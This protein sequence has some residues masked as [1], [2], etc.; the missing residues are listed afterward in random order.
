MS[1]EVVDQNHQNILDLIIKVNA[2]VN[3]KVLTYKEAYEVMAS[4]DYETF[5]E[6]SGAHGDLATIEMTLRHVLAQQGMDVGDIL[7]EDR[8]YLARDLQ[9]LILDKETTVVELSQKTGVARATITRILEGATVD[10][11]IYQRL[12][13]GL[14]RKFLFVQVKEFVHRCVNGGNL[15]I[16]EPPNRWEMVVENW[17]WETFRNNVVSSPGWSVE[18]KWK[19]TCEL[20]SVVNTAQDRVSVKGKMVKDV[21][22]PGFY[23][24]LIVKP[25][26][27]QYE[28]I[29]HIGMVHS[30]QE[31]LTVD[32]GSV[33]YKVTAGKLITTTGA[34]LKIPVELDSSGKV[35]PVTLKIDWD[36]E[37]LVPGQVILVDYSDVKLYDTYEEAINDIVDP[38]DE[39][40]KDIKDM[41]LDPPITSEKI[42]EELKQNL[43]EERYE[44]V[45]ELIDLGNG[46]WE[47]VV[48]LDGVTR[49]K[50]IT[51]TETGPTAE[52]QA[53]LLLDGLEAKLKGLD[54][55]IEEPT[56]AAATTAIKAGM[57]ADADKVKTVTKVSDKEY[58]V[59]LAVTVK[60]QE[61]TRDVNITV[62]L[63][64]EIDLALV[65]EIDAS[66]Q[67]A[68]TNKEVAEFDENTIAAEIKAFEKDGAT[69]TVEPADTTGTSP[70]VYEFEYKV[71]KGTQEKS[72][73]V[74]V[75]H[76]N[77]TLRTERKLDAI[78]ATL[79]DTIEVE[80][81]TEAAVGAAVAEALRTNGQTADVTAVTDNGDGTFNVDITDN[82]VT[83]TAKMH[84]TVT[85]P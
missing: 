72:N 41:E 40:F 43:G 63:Q 85:T 38:F 57:G 42:G 59:T 49:S 30:G 45:T 27:E 74:S 70:N 31:V 6:V 48:E 66:I 21:M 18:K 1:T 3:D 78:L 64:T 50:V 19:A 73:K 39:Y 80:E 8:K 69:V 5:L 12:M 53:K 25:T 52:E 55:T 24:M 54:L 17:K 56:E 13:H 51:V 14:D 28:K 15:Y 10:F 20:V 16:P 36:G 2:E 35:L 76:D 34:R 84:V 32:T 29:K 77:D 26:K 47:V 23:S 58:K 61:F 4:F 11:G 44:N 68:F 81:A 83:R 7:A 67:T 22:G 75:T 60:E 46:K 62:K 82:G 33:K 9:K 37:E 65:N 79:P 71:A